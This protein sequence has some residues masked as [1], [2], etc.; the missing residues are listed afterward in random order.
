MTHVEDKH[1]EIARALIAPV[2]RVS[3]PSTVVWDATNRPAPN[4]GPIAIWSAG[5]G[6]CV[7]LVHGWEADHR[8]M[9]AFVAPLVA[10]GRRVVAFD[11]PAHGET[12][13]ETATLPELAAALT[14]VSTL[15]GEVDAI[16]AHSVGCA[17]TAAALAEGLR[18]RRTAFIAP[19]LRYYADQAGVEGDALVAAL[20]ELGLD[21]APLDIRKSA[22]RIAVHVPLLLVHSMDDRVCDASN[23]SKI[24][25]LWNGSTVEFV[26]GLGHNRILHDPGVVGRIA[27]FVTAE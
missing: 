11:L 22:A 13:G 14:A 2:R 15:A 20:G 8:D 3:R 19:P 16:V 6:P 4:V 18:V 9:D 21:V 7:V 5:R 27:T 17:A 25:A 1:R 12:P 10:A 23:S 24:A 26:E